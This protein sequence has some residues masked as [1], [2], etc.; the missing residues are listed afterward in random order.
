MNKAGHLFSVSVCAM[1]FA[2]ANVA[3]AQDR[4]WG[5]NRSIQKI[6]ESVY[7]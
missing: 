5:V 3:L 7:R 1:I 4:E 2:A 6:S